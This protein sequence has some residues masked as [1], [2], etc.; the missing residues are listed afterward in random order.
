M[1][2]E[3]GHERSHE[4]CE[5]TATIKINGNTHPD[6]DV[7]DGTNHSILGTVLKNHDS[8]STNVME[9]GQTTMHHE[10]DNEHDD[11]MDKNFRKMVI[12][13]NWWKEKRSAY[14][15]EQQENREPVDKFRTIKQNIRRG[16]T[17]S[18][19]ERFENMFKLTE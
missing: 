7:V 12:N 8:T 1:E 9:P 2:S 3:N 5:T 14:E 18:L 6:D 13:E 4:H 15:K 10:H 11:E 16:N 17:R 19:K